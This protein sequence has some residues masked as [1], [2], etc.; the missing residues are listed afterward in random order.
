MGKLQTRLSV[1]I[2]MM[3]C[4]LAGVQAAARIKTG[5]LRLP[6]WSLLPYQLGEW[7]GRDTHFDPLFGT[8]P[9]DSS[10][11]R[12]YTSASA[13]VVIVYAGFHKDLP[14]SLDYHSPQL[15]YPAQ[16]WKIERE[17]TCL[18]GEFRRTWIKANEIQVT[19]DGGK[20]LVTW[21]YHAGPTP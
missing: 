8:D 10:L 2:C 13:T 5:H 1:A 7:Q 6:D 11:L 15:C 21:W 18:V 17:S 14:S 3:A 20:R 19:K 9:A 12:I 16:G 4:T